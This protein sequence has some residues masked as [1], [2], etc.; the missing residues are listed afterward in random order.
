[1]ASTSK[2]PYCDGTVR[3]DKKVCP[4]CGAV[5][6]NYTEDTKRQI[7]HPKT[8][9]E[10]KEYCAER[11][12]PLLRMRFFIGEDFKEPRAFG[13]Y[14]DGDRYI[15][16]KNK[17]NG[18]R[19]I[20]YQGP[21]EAYAV[22]ELFQKLLSEC[23]NRGIYPDGKPAENTTRSSYTAPKKSSA[24]GI[25]KYAVFVIIGIMVFVMIFKNCSNHKND[26]Y[27][28]FSSD[29]SVTWYHYGDSWYY[30]DIGTS[31]WYSGNP[32]YG[33]SYTDYYA[34]RDF[35]SDWGVT[36][37]KDSDTWESISSSSDSSYDSS[38]YDSWDSGGTDWS[39]DW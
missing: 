13:I 36:D 6:E 32:G 39:S 8:I 34:G 14:Q 4:H 38:S 16:Y 33:D 28:R 21:D 35:D 11:G 22:N 25:L 19:A 29:P 18:T 30:S 2:C 26:G 5:N 3:S 17:D 23:H 7:F 1:M 9:E 15:V 20:R 37:F 12:M 10:L 24:S 31:N 27:Y